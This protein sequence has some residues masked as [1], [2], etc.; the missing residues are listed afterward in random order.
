MTKADMTKA[1]M[2]KDDHW[3]SLVS[4]ALAAVVVGFASTILV[5]MQAAEAVGASEAQKISW[6][7]M[8]CFAMG[9]LTL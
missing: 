9:G 6:A 5:V 1:D 3:P 2:M 4:S 7:A 8:L